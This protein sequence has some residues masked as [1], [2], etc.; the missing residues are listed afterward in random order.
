MG[1]CTFTEG[2]TI[3]SIVLADA[4]RGTSCD[5]GVG[6]IF[7]TIGCSSSGTYLAL[8]LRPKPLHHLLRL[9]RT[10]RIT[11]TG[12]THLR[13]L[14]IDAGEVVRPPS[15]AVP[16]SRANPIAHEICPWSNLSLLMMVPVKPPSPTSPL[17]DGPR[18]RFDHDR[19]RV[20]PVFLRR[21]RAGAPAVHRAQQL[22][23]PPSSV[24]G[25][26]GLVVAL[27]SEGSSLLEACLELIVVGLFTVDFDLPFV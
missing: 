17:L 10:R 13:E 7:S 27:A 23:R 2:E 19:Q 3:P 26:R 15:L 4:L 12:S 21:H 20:P 16:G 8:T 11:H 5:D 1:G 9:T 6:S 18:E 22:R 14:V 24:E 25:L